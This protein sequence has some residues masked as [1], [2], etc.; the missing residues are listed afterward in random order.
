ME[1]QDEG[2]KCPIV[3][4]CT[5]KKLMK[6]CGLCEKYLETIKSFLKAKICDWRYKI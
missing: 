2:I 6:D 3:W 5:V 4:E 1:L